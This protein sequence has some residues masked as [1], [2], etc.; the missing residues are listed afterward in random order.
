MAVGRSANW[1]KSAGRAALN[2]SKLMGR[3][4]LRGGEVV[5]RGAL[6]SGEFAGKGLAR[7]AGVAMGVAAVAGLGAGLM[8]GAGS[9]VQELL[10]GDPEAFKHN[11]QA[12]LKGILVDSWDQDSRS[13]WG[14]VNY[15]GGRPI[16][17]NR[18]GG[19]AGSRVLGNY[20][21][22]SSFPG[23]APAGRRGSGQTAAADGSIVFGAYNLRR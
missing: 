18:L 13:D 17:G 16:Q 10:T 12:R 1:V 8:Q 19:V 9:E 14:T 20:G 7:H 6:R 15:L 23:R 2:T 5:G 22:T 4:A 11:A 3:G 21:Q